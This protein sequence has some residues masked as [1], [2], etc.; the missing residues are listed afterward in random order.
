VFAKT[1]ERFP[2]PTTNPATEFW[3]DATAAVKKRNR[4]FLFLAE[5]YWGTEQRLQALGF[6]YTYDKELY[7]KLVAHDAAGAQNHLL[8]TAGELL[9][10]G[11]HFLENHDE[12][13][14]VSRL[15]FPEH[16]AAALVVLGLPG[17]RF[18]HEGQLS[19]AQ[20]WSPVQLARRTQ[21]PVKVEIERMYDKLLTCLRATSVGQGE[22]EVLQPQAA[23]PENPTAQNFILIQWQG[24]KFELVVVNLAPHRGQCYAPLSVAELS[25]HD[26]S[27]KDLLGAEQF[28]RDGK[29]LESK[30]LYLDLP[31][32]GAQLFQ[33]EPV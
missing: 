20:L 6:D 17:M 22:V 24:R 25:R 27:V 10:S 11:A 31:G 13:R 14:I 5:A 4:E 8:T 16:Q 33:F 29:E 30:G 32:H 23:W 19:G 21:E 18:L 28:V 12:P 2:V 26:W 7:D 1:W 9:S 3:G 15:S